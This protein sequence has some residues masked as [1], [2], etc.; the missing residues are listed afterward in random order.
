MV[1]KHQLA[2]TKSRRNGRHAR[3]YVEC[4]NILLHLQKKKKKSP[5]AG[6]IDRDHDDAL[7]HDT[8]HFHGTPL[9]LGVVRC[10]GTCPLHVHVLEQ[11]VLAAAKHI[12]VRKYFQYFRLETLGLEG[13]RPAQ[14]TLSPNG[15]RFDAE[16]TKPRVTTELPKR[17]P[18]GELVV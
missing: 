15:W 5:E 12:S 8:A 16:E 2:G 13:I 18:Y 14:L 1:D 7:V 3:M 17:L 9:Q 10:A 11:P 4:R 6:R